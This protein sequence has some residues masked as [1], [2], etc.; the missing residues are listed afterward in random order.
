MDGHGFLI[1][2][3]SGN[4]TETVYEDKVSLP[5][6]HGRGGQSALRFS[7][8]RESARHNYLRKV[9][10]TLTQC[11]ISETIGLM[12]SGIIIGGSADLKSEIQKKDFFDPRLL[13]IILKVVDIAYG[14]ERGLNE[15]LNASSEVLASLDLLKEKQVLQ[16]FFDLIATNINK[17]VFGQKETE[18]DLAEGLLDTLFVNENES[19]LEDL[20]TIATE[21]NSKV[22]TISE[23]SS[24]G[25]QFIKGFGGWGGILRF[26]RSVDPTDI[27]DPE[28]LSG[29]E[30][31]DD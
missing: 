14:G 23:N 20:L 12:W 1:A 2:R 25:T 31:L 17:V 16:D 26:E 24:E 18:R 28:G 9:S 21:K 13:K 27:V 4:I 30:W 8:L 3:M 15:T 19:T 29:D 22:Y 5:P 10:E 6:K 11:L 7:R